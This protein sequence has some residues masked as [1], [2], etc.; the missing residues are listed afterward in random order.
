MITIRQAIDN[1]AIVIYCRSGLSFILPDR[2][3]SDYA[4]ISPPKMICGKP[5]YRWIFIS[6]YGQNSPKANISAIKHRTMFDDDGFCY[7][8]ENDY[9]AREREVNELIYDNGC[10]DWYTPY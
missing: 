6:I 4:A 2:Y 7:F 8:H 1:G 3:D 9:I 10:I 5:V